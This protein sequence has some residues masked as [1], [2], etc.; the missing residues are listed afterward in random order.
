MSSE[1]RNG[2][3]LTLSVAIAWYCLPALHLPRVERVMEHTRQFLQQAQQHP[4]QVV[5][6]LLLKFEPFDAIFR[7]NL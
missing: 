2:L 7:R 3:A 4:D 5:L 1:A 6:S